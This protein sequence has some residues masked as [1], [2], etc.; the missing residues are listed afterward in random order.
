[1]LR[2]VMRD[3]RMGLKKE[4]FI[5]IFRNNGWFSYLYLLG[6]AP[7]IMGVYKRVSF[8]ITYYALIIPFVLIFLLARI[9]PM[10]LPKII[11]LCPLNEQERRSYIITTF[12]MKML[13]SMLLFLVA[14]GVLMAYG[15]LT[16]IGAVF[17]CLT[18]F[19]ILLTANMHN[20]RTQIARTGWEETAIEVP[21]QIKGLT[22]WYAG[23]TIAA[24]IYIICLVLCGTGTGILEIKTLV[25]KVILFGI[26]PAIIV[27]LTIMTMSYFEH[28]VALSINYE[29]AYRKR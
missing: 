6:A 12:W 28:V 23:Q 27:G 18:A 1:M 10:R 20:S 2:R 8:T 9:L 15:Y 17:A 13:I 3:F 5:D 24:I 22:G 14:D 11:Y 7:L 26:A 4:V 21:E 19:C 29:E 25:G 16:V